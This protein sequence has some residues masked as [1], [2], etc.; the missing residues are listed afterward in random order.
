MRFSAETEAKLERLLSGFPPERKRAA[1]VPMLLFVQDEVGAVTPEVVEEVSRRLGVTPLDI[2]EVVS[3]YSML[4][5]KPVGRYHLQICTNISCL[6]VGGAE[7][8]EHACR[9][10]GIG[11]H[12]VTEDGLLSVEE[13]ECIGAC[14]W[15]PAMQINYEYRHHVTPEEFDRLIDELRQHSAGRSEE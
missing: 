9:R 2:E 8:F 3:Y 5:R 4:R 10:L 13:V 6:L 11:N 1:L 14:C 15:A 12:G 7:L